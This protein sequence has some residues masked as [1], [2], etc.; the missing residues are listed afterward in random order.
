MVI[1]EAPSGFYQLT[2]AG[3]QMLSTEKASVV[4]FADGR[5]GAQE[6]G[7][8]SPDRWAERCSKGT[9]WSR[10]SRSAALTAAGSASFSG[11]CF[12]AVNKCDEINFFHQAVLPSH[13]NR[14]GNLLLRRVPYPTK[15]GRGW[16]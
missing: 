11:G 1:A 15:Q 10:G 7:P 14:A 9:G 12:I 5:T 8:F 4:R 2:S 6:R 3:R 13:L 16:G